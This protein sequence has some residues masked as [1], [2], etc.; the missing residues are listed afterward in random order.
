MSRWFSA[1][2]ASTP[3]LLKSAIVAVVD[4]DESVREALC[5]L[6][7]V[8]DIHCRTFDR[9]EALLMAYRAGAFDCVVTDVR[10]PGIGGLELQTRLR[11]I[12]PSLPVIFI[13]AD[14]S[15]VTRSRAI[16]SGAIAYLVKPISAASL[17]EHLRAVLSPGRAR[18][19]GESSDE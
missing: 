19:A 4:D 6:L 9:A 2:P 18:G 12:A 14:T 11:K 5:D 8:M 16:A 15:A 1:M 13:S 3:H 7:A 17:Y 10:M